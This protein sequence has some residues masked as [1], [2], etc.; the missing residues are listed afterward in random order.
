MNRMKQ[1]L[2]DN[3]KIW[4]F[5]LIIGF[6][7]IVP[8]LSGGA[9]AVSLGIYPLLIGSVLNLRKEFKKSLT[10][11]IPFGICAAVGIFLFGVVMKP[12]LEH[13][14][15]SIIWLFMGLITG[16]MPA[17]L[18][19]ANEKGFRPMFLLPLV[20][21]LVLGLVLSMATG[22]QL[23]DAGASP[24][25]MFLGGG[26]LAIGTLVPGI[27]SSFIMMQLGIYDDVIGAFVSFQISTMLWV[28]LG[29][30]LFFLLII[31]I[32]H[33]AFEKFHGYAHFAAFGFLLASMVGV[34][35]GIRHY[36]DILLFLLGTAIL[37]GF[38]TLAQS[39]KTQ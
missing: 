37:Y 2:Q 18:K 29:A 33:I 39:K 4:V 5:G 34:Y 10:F 3:I 35:P 13:Y 6:A 28:A 25:M 11:L 9:L 30:V 32:V 8:G 20:I 17:F 31:K 14:E 15:H 22:Y 1:K 16:S 38:N 19:E 27:S 24:L 7:A 21:A 23:E 26:I 12:L 36:S